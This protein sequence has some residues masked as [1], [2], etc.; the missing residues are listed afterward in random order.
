MANS[1]D[2]PRAMEAT[3]AAEIFSERRVSSAILA[4]P[5]AIREMSVMYVRNGKKQTL[6][7][8]KTRNETTE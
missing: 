1:K 4:A 5:M 8:K 3:L 7:T 2:T 6:R